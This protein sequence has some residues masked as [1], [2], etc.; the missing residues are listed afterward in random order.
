M[1]S[2]LNL[3]SVSVLSTRNLSLCVLST[4]NLSLCLCCQLLISAQCLCCQLVISAH[5]LYCQLEISASQ[6]ST[7]KPPSPPTKAP[8]PKFLA[9]TPMFLPI[10]RF[11]TITVKQN[12]TRTV[13]YK[14]Y[15]N[16]GFKFETNIDQPATK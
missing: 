9:S 4:R 12:I 15:Y 6:Q 14:L 8:P 13:C 16:S 1:L 2:T 5:C 10:L 7:L 3:S 11:Q